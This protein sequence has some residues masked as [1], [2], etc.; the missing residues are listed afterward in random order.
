[1]MR[2][3]LA[4]AVS[5][6]LLMGCANPLEQVRSVDGR[7]SV[8]LQGVPAD[9]KI[10]IDGSFVG[11]GRAY[12]DKAILLKNGLHVVNVITNGKTILSEKVFLSGSMTKTL[13]IPAESQ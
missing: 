6:I 5:G 2:M 7:P 1:M 9:A 8:H 12:A 10:F 3:L 4:M 11:M 13:N